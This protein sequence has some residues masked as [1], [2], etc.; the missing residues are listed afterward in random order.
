MRPPLPT[1]F[2]LAF[3]SLPS[4]LFALAFA[5]VTVDVAAAPT[6]PKAFAKKSN[7][8]PAKVDVA[9]AVQKL[10]S[11]DEAQ[12]RAGLDELRTAGPS[13]AAGAPAV[14]EALGQG[15]TEPLTIQAI[16]TLGDLESDA[17][18]AV[19]VQYAGH[20]IV[21]VRRAAVRA[22]THTKGAGA[23]QALRR[24]LGDA[25]PQVRGNAAAGLGALKAHDAVPDSSRRST[26]A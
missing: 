1:P 25:D 22:L 8:A 15:L 7:A 14:A 18:T 5:T 24:A 21:A 11:G 9:P 17:G 26:V 23:A 20:R 13:A 3:R 10:H 16:D 6:Q 19:L 4:L 2:A 12:I